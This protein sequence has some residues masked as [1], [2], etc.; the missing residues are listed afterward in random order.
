M[1]LAGDGYETSR[2]G[3]FEHHDPLYAHVMPLLS[4]M[5]ETFSPLVDNLL[6]ARELA[7][8]ENLGEGAKILMDDLVDSAQIMLLRARLAIHLYAAASP[9]GDRSAGLASARAVIKDAEV[10]VA[11]RISQCP[12]MFPERVFGWRTK[13]PTSYTYGYLW[14]VKS[15][16]Y[17][18]RDYG[19]VEQG[20]KEAKSGLCYLNI[21]NPLNTIFNVGKNLSRVLQKW[22]KKIPLI[23]ELAN[24]LDAPM[25]EYV[26]PQDLY[27]PTRT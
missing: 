18:W 7:S 24:C 23:G 8:S 4:A 21:Q 10:L 20:S 3:F 26:F 13:S 14:T 9:N 11:R 27:G 16:Y 22:T 5:N 17:F 6:G 12:L 25:K 2:V 19:R 15:L 1:R